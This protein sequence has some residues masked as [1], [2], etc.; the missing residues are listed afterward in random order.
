LLAPAASL[1]APVAPLLAPAASSRHPGSQSKELT[2]YAHAPVA[3][4]SGDDLLAMLE[5]PSPTTPTSP[6]HVPHQSTRFPLPEVSYGFGSGTAGM[7][8]VAMGKMAM[9]EMAMGEMARGAFHPR[10][11]LSHEM[12][13][14]DASPLSTGGDDPFFTE[15]G[16]LDDDDQDPMGLYK[17]L[18]VEGLSDGALGGGSL[19]HLS[20][21]QLARRLQHAL[22][23]PVDATGIDSAA[24]NAELPWL[25]APLAPWHP[26][27]HLAIIDEEADSQRMSDAPP[28]HGHQMHQM[29]A[30]RMSDVPMAPGSAADTIPLAP[31][32]SFAALSSFAAPSTFASL[33][34]APA[35]SGSSVGSSPA[36]GGSE[37]AGVREADAMPT[38]EEV[39][40]AAGL[41]MPSLLPS[42]LSSSAAS[43]GFKIS[44]AIAPTGKPARNGAERKEWTAAEDDIIRSNVLSLGCKWRKIAAMLPG[45]SDDAVRNRWNRLREMSSPSP[46]L[47]PGQLLPPLKPVAVGE[48]EWLASD[49]GGSV[50]LSTSG[51][52]GGGA[53]V[54]PPREPREKPER[55]SWTKREDETILAS[56]SEMGHKWNKI[57]ERL[58]GRTDHAIRN[59]FH[60]LQTLLED[61][62]RQQQRTLAPAAPLPIKEVVDGMGSGPGS[63]PAT[64]S[65]LRLGAFSADGYGQGAE[66]PVGGSLPITPG[67]V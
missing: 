64:D 39:F 19:T 44:P 9:G 10:G 7:S 59:R 47:A 52:G 20:D 16:A 22:A 6:L 14:H 8:E 13:P 2:C 65:T 56:V 50:S 67:T 61:R 38:G 55:I 42:A 12:S 25:P 57:A 26:T 28:A 5:L 32:A 51:G 35:A 48:G 30:E 37:G 49:K 24:L 41:P 36:L 3:D 63:G 4:M 40:T 17:Q 21:E 60:R 54:A 34:F 18:G 46:E 1:P 53:S 58:P 43:A 11:V 27:A 66:S 45:R 29:H 15:G 31:P 33:P 23:I 62:Q